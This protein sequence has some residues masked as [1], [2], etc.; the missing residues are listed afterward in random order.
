MHDADQL[1]YQLSTLR[2]YARTILGYH[3]N[4]CIC[5]CAQLGHQLSTLIWMYA[6][7][8]MYEHDVLD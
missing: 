6:C 7:R 1:G 8:Y 3:L 2:W 5:M 4:A